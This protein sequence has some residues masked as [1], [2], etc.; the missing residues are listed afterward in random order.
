MGPDRAVGAGHRGDAA[1]AQHVLRKSQDHRTRAAGRRHLE[2]LV[3]QLGDALGQIDLCHPFGERREHLAEIDLLKGLAVELMAGD[4]AD[5]ND[6]R[7]RILEGGVD[8]DR[9]VAG[10]GTPGHEQYAGLAGQLAISLGH[11]GRT[12]FLAAGDEAN[13]GRVEQR[14]EHFEIAFAGDAER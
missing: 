1:I 7:R 5:E 14:V 12:A 8:A 9:G 2:G 4:L 13:F 6:H 11:K 3:D 10:A